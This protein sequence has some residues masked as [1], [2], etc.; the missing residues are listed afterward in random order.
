MTITPNGLINI[1]IS[2]QSVMKTLMKNTDNCILFG[3]LPVDLSINNFKVLIS[4]SNIIMKL[5]KKKNIEILKLIK[6]MLITSEIQ[7]TAKI[8]KF[9]LQKN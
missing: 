5:R 1:M 3:I 7:S 6:L 2:K 9:T 8:S 4:M